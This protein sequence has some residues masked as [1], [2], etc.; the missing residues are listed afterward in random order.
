[1]NI[2]NKSEIFEDYLRKVIDKQINQLI[3]ACFALEN[4]KVH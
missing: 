3:K 4:D 2:E 1:M